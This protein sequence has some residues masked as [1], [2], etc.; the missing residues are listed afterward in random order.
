MESQRIDFP[1]GNH[2]YTEAGIEAYN[3]GDPVKAKQM[4][5]DAGYEGT[6]IRLLVSDQLPGGISIRRRCSPSSWPRP[7][8]TSR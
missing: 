7:G 1:K 5:K 6:P 3:V 8:S 2:W 4:A